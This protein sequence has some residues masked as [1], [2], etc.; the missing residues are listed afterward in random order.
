MGLRHVKGHRKVGASAPFFPPDFCFQRFACFQRCKVAF[1]K[2]SLPAAPLKSSGRGPSRKRAFWSPKTDTLISGTA[3]PRG[4]EFIRLRPASYRQCLRQ[5]ESIGPMCSD[6]PNR[7]NLRVGTA[8]SWSAPRPSQRKRRED[9]ALSHRPQMSSGRLFLDR[10]G[11]HQSPTL[12]HR[13]EQ[14]QHAVPRR[15]GKMGHFYFALTST[16]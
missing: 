6:K 16:S 7:Q 10:V 1:P 14:K 9:H 3:V 13:H 4:A 12:L 5:A 8:S 15:P 2:S 11:R